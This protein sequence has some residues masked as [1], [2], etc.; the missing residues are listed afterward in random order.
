MTSP[1][2]RFVQLGR[3]VLINYGPDAGKLAVIVD[4]IDQSRALVDGP[5]SATGVKRQALNFKRMALTDIVVKKVSRGVGEVAL[6]KLVKDQDVLG[7][8]NKTATAQRLS[9]RVQRAGQNDF[10]RFKSMLA[11]KKRNYA[12]KAATAKLVRGNKPAK[13]V[14]KA[15]TDKKAAK[16]K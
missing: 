6:A 3:V 11:K 2:R 16:A 15:K 4:V 10:D 5:F 13:K 9:A 7:Q 1:F 14:V 8:W 12:I